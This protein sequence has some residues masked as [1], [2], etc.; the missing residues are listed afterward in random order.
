M[1]RVE[2]IGL[3]ESVE[4]R[5]P[6]TFATRGHLQWIVLWRHF[7]AQVDGERLLAAW[8][9]LPEPAQQKRCHKPIVAF[10]VL[11][12]DEEIERVAPC[13]ECNNASVVSGGEDQWRHIDGE[14]SQGRHFEALLAEL[15][16]SWWARYREGMPASELAQGWQTVDR[17]RAIGLAHQVF[18]T[19]G[20]KHVLH[21]QASRP[22]AVR[23]DD[24]LLQ[25]TDG[26]LAEVHLTWSRTREDDPAWPSTRLFADLDA[27]QRGQ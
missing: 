25:L 14:S 27:W 3:G 8:D 7:L 5:V 2:L 24:V 1:Q 16:P 12:G 10:R 23:Q 22:V 11:E 13:P 6:G 9:D 15:A 21:G 20:A 18:A 4:G 19:V 17:A 26:R